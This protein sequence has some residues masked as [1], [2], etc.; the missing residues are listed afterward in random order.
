MAIVG[1]EASSLNLLALSR[2]HRAP[3]GE[4]PFGHAHNERTLESHGA[5]PRSQRGGVS[6]C[7]AT[8]SSLC[9]NV[10]ALHIAVV[11]GKSSIEEWREHFIALE[12]SRPPLYLVFTVP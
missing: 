4:Q 9:Q 6:K 10:I 11:N 1:T 7:V 2:V 8:L 3:R 5:L 12:C